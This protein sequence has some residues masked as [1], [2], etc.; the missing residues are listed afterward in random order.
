MKIILANK[1]FRISVLIAAVSLLLVSGVWVFVHFL[2]TDT[3]R[4]QQQINTNKD[5]GV[6]KKYQQMQLDYRETKVERE[7]LKRVVL[8]KEDIVDL[9]Q[10]LDA[11][12]SA[13][14]VEHSVETVEQKDK[15]TNYSTAMF[16][17]KIKVSGNINS[18]SSYID[19][20]NSLPY[21]A[22][23][24]SVSIHAVEELPLEQKAVGEINLVIV[25]DE[26]NEK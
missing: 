22:K 21:L 23:I 25:A 3:I 26:N 15:N 7:L 2:N 16:Y 6:N 11:Y 12:A 1:I 5:L 4:V 9:M 18:I 17:Y 24:E 10:M 19:K 20:I 14:G 13:S 8:E